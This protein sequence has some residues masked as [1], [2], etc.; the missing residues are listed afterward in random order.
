MLDPAT[1]AALTQ[2]I[3]GLAVLLTA[4]A[5][6]YAAIKGHANGQKIESVAGQVQTVQTQTNGLSAALATTTGNAAFL[7]GQT[8]QPNPTAGNVADVAAG[9]P[10]EGLPPAGP[11]PGS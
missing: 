3:Q 8:G 4:A 7:A 10:A 11:V 2:L 9:G 5:A 6:L 1:I